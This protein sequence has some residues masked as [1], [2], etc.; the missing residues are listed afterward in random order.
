MGIDS[1]QKAAM[2]SLNERQINNKKDV[3]INKKKSLREEYLK[4][5]KSMNR[6]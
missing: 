4:A 3:F 5:T 2:K 1:N 6:R